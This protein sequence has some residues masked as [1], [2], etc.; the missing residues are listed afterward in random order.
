MTL[1][2]KQERKAEAL[3]KMEE[4]NTPACFRTSR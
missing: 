2:E 1:R 3:K 4:E